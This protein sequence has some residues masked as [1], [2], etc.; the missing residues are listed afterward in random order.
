M[1]QLYEARCDCLAPTALPC[2]PTPLYS[3]TSSPHAPKPILITR[4]VCPIMHSGTQIS[5]TVD[6]VASNGP[7]EVTVYA[8]EK[9][10]LDLVPYPLPQPALDIVFRLSSFI[11]QYQTDG[12]RIAPG[13]VQRLFEK[14][15]TRWVTH[16]ACW[17]CWLC[18][19]LHAG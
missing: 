3:L 13:A 8:I 5:V 18:V 2:A 14:L 7:V 9:A 12:Y 19:L 17:W 16:N 1:Y 10:F 6:T 11:N 4:C 15:L